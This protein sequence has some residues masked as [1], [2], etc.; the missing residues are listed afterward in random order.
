MSEALNDS[1]VD[2]HAERTLPAEGS[3]AAR[4][5]RRVPKRGPNLTAGQVGDVQ[6]RRG[7]LETG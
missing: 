4:A 7:Y 1:P 6:P 3:G 2:C 5:G